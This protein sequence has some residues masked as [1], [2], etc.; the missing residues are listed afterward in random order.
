[1]T[2]RIAKIPGPDHPITITPNPNR[3]VVTVGGVVIADTSRALNLKE[4][5]YPAVHYIPREDA[6]MDLLQRSQTHTYCPYKGE[7]SYFSIPTGGEKSIDAVW[8]YEAPYAAVTAIRDHL[9]FYT[10]RIDNLVET[11]S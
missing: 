11:K 10:S 8:T 4:A 3:V 5:N 2:D 6:R 9:A 7:A 1:M